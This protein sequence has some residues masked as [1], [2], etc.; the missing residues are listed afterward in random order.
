M[1]LYKDIQ[2]RDVP[3]VANHLYLHISM[4]R[5]IVID[6]KRIQPH[7]PKHMVFLM[8]PYKQPLVISVTEWC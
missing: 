8:K 3:N 6:F 1:Y 4:A 5:F 7:M 2:L